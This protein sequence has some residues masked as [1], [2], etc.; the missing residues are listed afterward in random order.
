MKEKL[1]KAVFR[2]WNTISSTAEQ[3]LSET[4]LEVVSA[5]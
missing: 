5:Q 1:G 3:L 4:L 2:V